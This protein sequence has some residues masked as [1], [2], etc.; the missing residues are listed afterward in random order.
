[1]KFDETRPGDGVAPTEAAGSV[2]SGPR[3]PEFLTNELLHEV[4]AAS[5]KKWPA[6]VALRCGEMELTYQELRRRVAMFARYLRRR[7][8]GGGD[9]VVLWLPRGLEMYVALLGALEAGAYYV[10][11]DRDYPV[12]RVAFSALDCQARVLVT[13]REVLP[14]AGPE[15]SC[16]VIWF[17][18]E[19]DRI[20]AEAP[21]PLR[22]AETGVT[23]EHLAYMIYTSGTTGRP[24]GVMIPHRAIRHFVFAEGSV[25]GFLESDV[26]AQS[27]S[28]SFDLS[29][30]E[31]WLSLAAG[32][33][34]VIVTKPMLQAGAGLGRLLARQGVT[35]WSTVPT[36]L[37][38][39]E[40]D[41]PAL[42]LLILG[43]EACPPELV[44]RW[45]RPNRR[46]L[47]TYG[48][49]ET[50][51]T[52]TWCELK[53]D[54]PV[55]IGEPLPNYTAYVLDEQRRLV[56]PGESGELCLG[57]PG[58]ALGYRNRPKLTA[59][60]F[61]AN[62]FAGA[63]A[64]DPV[65]YRTGDLVSVNARGEIE[66][67]GRLDTQ[68]KIR[69]YRVEL[70]EI[71]AV[72]VELGG[73]RN[74]VA[75]LQA[76][77][78]G[79]P[80]LVAYLLP[81]EGARVD[82]AG[83]RERCR[84][85]L[86]AYMVPGLFEVVAHLP[87]LPSGKVDRARLPP[88]LGQPAM[89]RRVAPPGSATERALYEAWSEVFEPASVSLDDD[90]FQDLGGHSLRA[91]ALVSKLRRNARFQH[92]SIRDI[93][94][95][96]TIRRLA[97]HL[98][99]G[100]RRGGAT[101]AEYQATPWWRYAGCTVAQGVSLVVI[102]AFYSLQLLVPYLTYAWFIDAEG[103]RVEAVVW[104]MLIFLMSIPAML[105]MSVGM[106]WLVIGQTR[107][108]VY[109]LW[110]TY[111][112]RWW[113]VQRLIGVVPT[114]YLTGTPLMGLYFRL[115][116]ARLGA[117][118]HL[119]TDA[120]DV[121]DLVEMGAGSSAGNGA[122]LICAR[123]ENGQLKLGRIL[124]GVGCHVGNGSVVSAGAVLRDRARL[125]ELSLLPTGAV[126]PA[127]EVWAGSP[128]AK[129]GMAPPPAPLAP[130]NLRIAH[131][132][133]FA[134]L[135][136]VFPILAILPIFPGMVLVAEMDQVTES[137]DWLL[138]SPLLAVGFI[139]T[140]CLE[141]AVLKWLVLG[142]VRAGSWP[143]YSDFYVRWWFVDKLMELSLDIVNSLYA[144][145]YLNPW[146]KLLGVQVG[147]RAEV[148]TASSMC[149]DLLQLGDECFIADAVLLG[150][151][152]VRDGRLELLPTRVGKRAFVGNSALIPA[153]SVIGDD[154]LVG[155]L[156]VPPREQGQAEQA[157]SSWFGS[158][159]ILL[160]RRQQAH[161]FD[162]GSTFKPPP[163]LV[164]QR[165]AIEALRVILPPTCY[166]AMN[167]LLI[168]FV[169]D[170]NESV[171]FL[172]VAWRF[173]FMYMG[174]ALAASLGVVALKWLVVG[175]YKPVEKPLWSRYVWRSEL[176]TSTYENVAVPLF[177]EHLQGTPFL[178]LYLRLLGAKIGRG[179]YMDT[180]D[181][182][183][184]DVVSVGDRAALN[185]GCGLQTHLFEDRVMKIS[186]IEIGAECTVGASAIVLYDSVM[187]PGAALDDLSMLMKGETLP[188]NTVWQGSP[189]RRRKA[190][191]A[192]KS[193]RFGAIAAGP[194]KAGR[195]TEVTP[196]APVPGRG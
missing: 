181:I 45:S 23:P 34:I 86:P 143:V 193:R 53:P 64:A 194:A 196:P 44:R 166:I 10:P 62:P 83:L 180:A 121:P 66:F 176:V 155:C 187:E 138:L 88:I 184:F 75:A 63:D 148:S 65:L 167:S 71:E 84:E 191:S 99:D 192:G 118:V 185:E 134:G 163:H 175:R 100:V 59:E 106:K 122:S 159:A 39:Q 126:I 22:A 149:H 178:N 165:Y 116:G 128:A 157:G 150:A 190:D 108:G 94:D 112:F 72:L 43:G 28:L 30:E 32:A 51:I 78:S 114:D 87:T 154:V 179:V 61:I 169:L 137:Y 2:L 46:L 68:V 9:A 97:A 27:A 38:M 33:K 101:A 96:P 8:V 91:A 98:E 77:E 79:D 1:V 54:Q 90:F 29:Q 151:P 37:A 41:W 69:G 56:A 145:M 35:V 158:P 73:L 182:T 135:F 131:G 188:A 195:E 115:L 93:Y 13:T 139:V 18:D 189:A 113:F 31:I 161:Q 12:E 3:R 57:G 152:R 92:V 156:S 36:L 107:P 111:Y 58:V 85:R 109:P 74:A 60:K 173:P 124:V 48:P 174:L 80:A 160:P 5:A 144:T 81:R 117:G 26:V 24:K 141:I 4:L 172:G 186:T 16:E 127:G 136:F 133:I 7:G 168:S 119:D 67:L 153:G 95:H 146:Y 110:G 55:T 15:F 6:R 129:V 147:T 42:R 50:T 49:T 52:A 20:A 183:E 19:Q 25:T 82:E 104:S 177:C 140:M 17:D 170:L 164:A 11:M 40:G 103:G 14:V 102:L 89:T 70:A 76:G 130:L 171:G 120:L 162:E 125:G 47:N 132:L 105:L 123:V 21:L 142:K